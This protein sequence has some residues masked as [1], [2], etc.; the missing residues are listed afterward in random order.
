MLVSSSV[1]RD[2][3]QLFQEM[4]WHKLNP[5]GRDEGYVAG[6]KQF[7]NHPILGGSFY[8]IDYP[9]FTWA[10]SGEFISF[11]PPR[12]HNTVIQVLASC[13]IVGM[14]GYSFH[15]LQTLWLFLHRLSGKKMFAFSKLDIPSKAIMDLL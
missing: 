5:F 11:F 7:L 4:L 15:R 8:P 10:T 2:L 6:W 1:P 13:G 14:I 9:L 3:I 12:W